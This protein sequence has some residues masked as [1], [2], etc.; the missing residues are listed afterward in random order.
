MKLPDRGSRVGRRTFLKLV[1]GASVALGGS[2]AWLSIGRTEAQVNPIPFVDPL[3]I[4][5]VISRSGTLD[6]QPLF[7]VTMR[8]F[9]Q[10]L[11]RDLPSTPLWGYNGLYPGPTFENRRGRPINVRW[12]NNLPDTHMFPIDSTLHGDEPGQ[13]A[14]R[15][16]VHLHGAKVE[17]DSDG[18]P[19]A[20]FTRGFAKVGPF[21]D[22]KVYHYPNDQQATELWYHDHG[23]GTTRLNIFAGL[24]GFYFIRDDHED[25]LNLPD[26][27]FEIPLMIQDRSFNLDGSLFYPVIDAGGDP[28]QRVPPIWVPE[29]FGDTVLVNGKVWPFLEVEP[30]KYRFRMLN[31]SNA[32]W[33]HLTLN[34]AGAGGVPNGR[35]GPVFN[36]IGTDGG[37]RPFPVKA[38]EILTAPSERYDIII[39]FAGAEGK[40]FVLSNDGPAPFPGGG[41][42]VPDKVMLFKVT[43]RLSGTDTSSLP[44]SLGPGNEIEGEDV[45]TRDL[46]LSELDSADPYVNPIIGRID[47]RGTPPTTIDPWKMP[48]TET[49][50]AGSVEIWRLINTTGDGHPIHI[51]LVQFQVLDR[52]LFAADQI[53]TSVSP[54]QVTKLMFTGLRTQPKDETARPYLKYEQNARKDTVKA[55]PGEVTRVIMRFDLPTGT[56]VRRDEKFRYVLHCHILEHEDNDMM[57]P[58]DVIG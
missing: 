50:R 55:F 5:P 47:A 58:Y 28:D 13:P 7:N 41:D 54:P 11:H 34:E 44:R 51:H 42:V 53:D 57:R 40:S 18:Y 16:V 36:I 21:F 39:D 15:T 19:E 12:M 6:D 49:P 22:N 14:V 48:V 24:A 17:P 43:K 4:P 31:A 33:Y 38:T 8:A 10:K 23:L 32:R 29:F 30:R 35:P 9:K 46:V 27:D 26:G 45:K 20:W 1:G 3:P 56:P 25:S 37:L 2:G 52:Q